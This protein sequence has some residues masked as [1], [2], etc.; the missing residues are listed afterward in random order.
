MHRP[1][2]ELSLTSF[3]AFIGHYRYMDTAMLQAQIHSQWA[4][5]FCNVHF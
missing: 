1:T 4:A 5:R 2:D 3:T